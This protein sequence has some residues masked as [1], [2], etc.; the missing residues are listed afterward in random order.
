[1]ALLAAGWENALARQARMA[2]V[3]I[4][5]LHFTPSQIYAQCSEVVDMIRSAPAAARGRP[6]PQVRTLP[7]G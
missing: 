4:V 3:D 6:L 2:A 5:V 7:A 1:M